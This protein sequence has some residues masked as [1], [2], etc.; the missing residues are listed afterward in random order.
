M[1]FSRSQFE[2]TGRS[3]AYNPATLLIIA[4]C[5]IATVGNA[6]LWAELAKLG[7]LQTAQDLIKQ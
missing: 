6:A 3:R 4:S 2:P 1:P 7:R 5:W